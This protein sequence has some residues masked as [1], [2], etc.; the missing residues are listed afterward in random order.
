MQYDDRGI[1]EAACHR[2]YQYL[3]LLD[4]V[5]IQRVFPYEFQDGQTTVLAMCQA[6]M[7]NYIYLLTSF[8]ARML[9]RKTKKRKKVFATLK[10]LGGV[11]EQ[12]IKEVSPEDAERL[13]PEELKLVMESDAAMTEDLIAYNIIPIDT[14]TIANAIVSLT[15]VSFRGVSN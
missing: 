3:V 9:E 14:P 7:W 1:M 8:C 13:I 15:E 5:C 6:T 11:L 4:I 2:H 10:V 12:M